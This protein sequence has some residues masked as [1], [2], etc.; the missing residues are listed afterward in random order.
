M[1][2]WLKP[3]VLKTLPPFWKYKKSLKILNSH[4]S[5]L[6]QFCL[7]Q[8]GFV[9]QLSSN[10]LSLSTNTPEIVR[11]RGDLPQRHDSIRKYWTGTA[12]GLLGVRERQRP[13]LRGQ[14]G[15]GWDIPPH[16][17][18]ST[19]SLHSLQCR[20]QGTASSR[21]LLIGCPHSSHI[22]N[23]SC[24]ILI[25]DPRWIALACC[26]SL[27]GASQRRWWSR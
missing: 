4:T 16:F 1:G 21:A 12:V 24:R 3:P 6:R 9:I 13:G 20:A 2:E 5:Q 10:R 22:P 15:R 17:R 19:R 26:R 11:Q 14:R 7:F 25:K 8:H 18:E 23:L 27:L